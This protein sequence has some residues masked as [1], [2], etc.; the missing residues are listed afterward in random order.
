MDEHGSRGDVIFSGA[1][2]GEEI[3]HFYAFSSVVVMPSESEANSMVLLEALAHGKAI[4]CSDILAFR[5][6]AG[7]AVMYFRCGDPDDLAEN[8]VRLMADRSDYERRATATARE[9]SA[10]LSWPRIAERY[11]TFYEGIVAGE[12]HSSEGAAG[13]NDGKVRPAQPR[14]RQSM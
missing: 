10:E 14:G 8:L 3:D 1:V 4:L 7:E 9:L 2:T 5:K 11:E 13:G 12:S 6:V